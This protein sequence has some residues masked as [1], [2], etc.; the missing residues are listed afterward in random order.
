[1]KKTHAKTKI[2]KTLL[3]ENTQSINGHTKT[4]LVRKAYEEPVQYEVGNATQEACIS[5][6]WI[7]IDEKLDSC[8]LMAEARAAC[9]LFPKVALGDT[10]AA[11]LAPTPK[12]APPKTGRRA[13][14]AASPSQRGR[15][16]KRRSRGRS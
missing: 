6:L 7:E 3:V 13:S 5:A 14:I 9:A 8:I 12:S 4:C 16:K 1:M 10:L 2:T 15:Q 11:K